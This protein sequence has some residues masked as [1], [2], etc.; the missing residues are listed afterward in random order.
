MFRW[1]TVYGNHD[2]APNVTRQ[3]ILRAEQSYGKSCYTSQADVNLPG[4]T[5]YFI[6]V[7]GIDN[8]TTADKE[9]PVMIWWFFDSRGGRTAENRIPEY[10]DDTVVE[11]FRNENNNIRSKWGEV[12]SLVFVHIPT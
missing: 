12:P 11:W 3:E 9:K 4:V 6:P 10:V 8:G 7:Y 5:N 2:S 1:A